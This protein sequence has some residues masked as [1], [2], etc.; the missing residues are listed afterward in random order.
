M[1]IRYAS[2][3]EVKERLVGAVDHLL[4]PAVGSRVTA[5]IK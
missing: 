3:Q 5:L 4:A 2:V 1:G